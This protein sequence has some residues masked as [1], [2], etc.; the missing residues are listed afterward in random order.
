MLVTSIHHTVCQ[1][2][3]QGADIISHSGAT[4]QVTALCI[5]A[6]LGVCTL[7]QHLGRTETREKAEE[8]KE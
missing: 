1:S 3:F 5:H 6:H 7:R 4:Q 8:E 2:L